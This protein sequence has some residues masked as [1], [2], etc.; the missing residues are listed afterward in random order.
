MDLERLPDKLLFFHSFCQN[1]FEVNNKTNS[2][3]HAI[4]ICILNYLSLSITNNS[5]IQTKHF[6]KH[7]FFF[8]SQDLA[9]VIFLRVLLAGVLHKII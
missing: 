4:L 3:F 6:R 5:V 8:P 2:K 7:F 9:T 1:S